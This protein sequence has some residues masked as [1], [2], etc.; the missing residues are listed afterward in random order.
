MVQNTEI[1]PSRYLD[2]FIENRT[3]FKEAF[4]LVGDAVL[5]ERIKFPEARTA[6][7][8]IL[9]ENVK[10][11]V[12]T[13]L[14]DRPSFYRVLLPGEGFYDDETGE[15]RPLNCQSG[16]VVLIAS[17]GVRIFSS[18][19]LLTG[20]ETDSIGVT[21]DSEIIWRFKGEANFVRILGELDKT[22]KAKVVA[23]QN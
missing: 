6:S 20:Y 3:T 10:N 7:G 12:G 21:R 11:Q 1:Q 16:D 13:M 17:A 18:F 2:F 15:D 5:V 22:A 8:I 14:A 9:A 23:S 19:P 4:E